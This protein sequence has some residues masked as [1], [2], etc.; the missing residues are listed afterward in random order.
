MEQKKP[1]R[2]KPG[3]PVP[4]YWHKCAAVWNGFVVYDHGKLSFGVLVEIDDD[5]KFYG[6]VAKVKGKS[7]WGA[8]LPGTI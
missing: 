7:G 8:L 4:I 6:G 1:P 3:A 5:W 2:W